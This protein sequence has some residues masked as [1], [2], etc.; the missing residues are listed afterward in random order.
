MPAAPVRIAI[1]S[2]LRDSFPKPMGR[3]LA[4]LLRA[5][6][7]EPVLLETGLED[8]PVPARAGPRPA[9]AEARLRTLL[10]RLRR[11]LSYRRL[12]R[13]LARVDAVIVVNHLPAAYHRSFFDDVRLR[14][15]LPRLPILLYDL[16]YL[17]TDPFWTARLA[18][19]S[20]HPGTPPGPHW[21]LARYDHHLCVTEV[22]GEEL[23]PGAEDFTRIGLHLEDPTLHVQANPQFQA[24]IDFE[25]PEHL[26]ERAAQVAACVEA[27]VPFQVLHGRYTLEE[28]RAVYRSCGVYFLAHLESFGVPIA[29]VQACG[30]TVLT[31]DASWCRPHHLTRGVRTLDRLPD[32]VQCYGQDQ[33]TL[34]RMLRELRANHDPHRI[35]ERF[36]AQQ[37]AFFRGDAAALGQ[38]VDRLARGDLHAQSHRR[39]PDLAAMTARR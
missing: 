11:E 27:G 30:A 29:E 18:G 25:R 32:N 7:A 33:A 15:D 26:R 6:G 36:L 13:Q 1:L 34:V 28:I 8:L 31:P 35:R 2:D 5:A 10:R 23:L 37:P 24:L 12:R 16:I 22:N 38:V 17:G 9:G 4:R 20:P 3:G 39:Y 14:G 21:G 19:Q